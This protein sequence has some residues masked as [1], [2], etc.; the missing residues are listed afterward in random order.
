MIHFDISY[1]LFEGFDI[2]ISKVGVY[3]SIWAFWLCLNQPVIQ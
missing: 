1:G 2:V 3:W